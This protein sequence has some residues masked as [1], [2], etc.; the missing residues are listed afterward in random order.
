MGRIGAAELF[1]I[2][3]VALLI[4]GPGK[5]ADDGKGLGQGLKNF[6]KGLHPEEEPKPEG[7]ETPPVTPPAQAE[8]PAKTAAAVETNGQ[9]TKRSDNDGGPPPPAS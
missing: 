1:L 8:E 6:K 3:L 5:L 7:S 9:A 2:L 4:F